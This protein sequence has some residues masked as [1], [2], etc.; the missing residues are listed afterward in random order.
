[1]T[2][3]SYCHVFVHIAFCCFA[4]LFSCIILYCKLFC[5]E[6]RCSKQRATVLGTSS[7]RTRIQVDTDDGT[8]ESLPTL[9]EVKVE[10][11]MLTRRHG[12]GLGRLQAAVVAAEKKA[13]RRITEETL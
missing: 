13:T 5:G 3:S 1:V 8:T 12:L 10:L 4:Y 9:S 11:L 7:S 2:A 6:E